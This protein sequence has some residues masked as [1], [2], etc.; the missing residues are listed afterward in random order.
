MRILDK[1]ILKEFLGPFLF[2]VAAFTSI[3][4]GA[5]TLL[6]IADYVT[7]YGA[8]ALAAIK[9]FIL[10]LPRI[11][12]YTFPMA[13]LLGSLMATSRLSGASELI[14]MRTS[15]QSFIRLA[16]PIFV[17]TFIISLCTIAFNEYVVPWTNTKYE[18]VLHIEIMQN[19]NPGI[20][21][22]VIMRDIQKGQISHLLY[23][24]RYNP[25]TKTLENITLQEFQNE[26]VIR[27]ENAPVATWENGTWI[28]KDG[29]IYD[30]SDDGV[31]RM[32]HFKKQAIPYAQSPE[33]IPKEKKNYDEMTIRELLVASKAYAAAHA[34]ITPIYMEIHRRFSLPM[35]SFVFSLVG[36]PLGVQ[37]Q[38]SSSSIGFGLSVVII[39]IYYAVMTFLEALGNAH[40]LSPF[41][42]VWLPNFIAC[43]CG[44]FLIKKA[45]N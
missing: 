32:M 34:D 11:I 16:K 27:V 15:G 39:F 19:L 45:N 41:I 40:M 22:H 1:Y 2:G 3:F 12:V 6:K 37:K 5:D 21:D 7:K 18:Q 29:I 31:N 33:D 20:T 28:M 10:A 9:I 44:V 8:S 43:I 4:L 26:K 38:R 36:A 17:I 35:A 30:L 24:R 13:V 25:E 42:A 14:V 23:A